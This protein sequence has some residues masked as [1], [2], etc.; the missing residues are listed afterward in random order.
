MTPGTN[1]GPLA[2]LD[3]YENLQRQVK[4]ALIDGATLVYGD[5]NQIKS[6]VD[7]SKGI[8]FHPAIIENIEKDNIA[9]REEL[10]G[11]VFSLYKVKSEKEAIELGKQT[12]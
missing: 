7:P 8:Y 4:Q 1:I 9:Y 3:L 11:P 12:I 5:M 10:F 2:R 6:K